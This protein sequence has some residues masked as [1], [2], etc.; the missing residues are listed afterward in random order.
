LIQSK[1]LRLMLPSE[2]SREEFAG[3]FDRSV[4][5]WKPYA[6]GLPW[7]RNWNA[8]EKLFDAL[9]DV[10]QAGPSENRILS[11]ISE[12]GAGGTT[13]SRMLA[14]E[15]AS[16]G[17]P[18]LVARPGLRNPQVLE[19]S[20]FLYRTHVEAMGRNTPEMKTE[21]P[22]RGSDFEVPW[23]IVYDV[24]HWEGRDAELRSFLTGLTQ[25]GRPVVILAVNTPF[26]PVDLSRSTRIKRIASLTHEL[27][28]QTALQLGEHLNKFLAP[29]GKE[30][31]EHEWRRFWEVHRPEH[32]T[33]S[34][35]HFWIALE[36]W[37]RGQ[38]DLNE[39]IQSWLYKS[40]CAA[41]IAD[42]VRVIVLEI[43]ALS[44]ERQ[45]LPEGLMPLSPAHRRPYSWL[46]EDVRAHVPALALIREASGADKVWA[47]AHD[48]LGRYL[49]T[50]TFFD[51]SMLERLGLAGGKCC[52]FAVTP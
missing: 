50:S 39:S 11:I 13:F 5:S 42:D 19:L 25:E 2:L 28:L 27:T 10:S 47:M 44:I 8:R 12:S 6:A 48:L 41:E 29:L 35:A 20:N 9:K 21:R 31:S 32:I 36:F 1:D 52:N 23:L 15:A 17:Y 49:V 30:R 33:A 26:V 46:L 3:F 18:T 37:L 38:L 43:A 51:H 7:R 14:F 34:I 22:V 16:H 24:S 45:P 40:F 4:E